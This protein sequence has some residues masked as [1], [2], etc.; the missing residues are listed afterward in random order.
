MHQLFFYLTGFALLLTIGCASSPQ[1]AATP[2]G[3]G[4]VPSKNEIVMSPG[5]TIT[6]NT[7]TGL[8]VIKAGEGLK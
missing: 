7:P 8:M 2:V 4:P 1:Q 5:M 6:A 3:D